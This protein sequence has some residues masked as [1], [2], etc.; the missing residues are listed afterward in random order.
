MLSKIIKRHFSPKYQICLI[1]QSGRSGTTLR[2]LY[3]CEQTGTQYFSCNHANNYTHEQASRALSVISQSYPDAFIQ[4][5]YDCHYRET[6]E[7]GNI[8]DYM[9]A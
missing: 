8:K 6:D 4:S 7:R 9:C 5:E 3:T 2:H 1:T